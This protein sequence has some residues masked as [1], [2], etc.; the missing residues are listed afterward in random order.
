MMLSG[1]CR[2]KK[3]G[4]LISIFLAALLVI[5][6]CTSQA[7][8][9]SPSPTIPAENSETLPAITSPGLAG[10]EEALQEIYE[11]VNPSVVNI[12]VLQKEEAIFPSFPEIPGFP[13]FGFPIPEQPEY[14][15][16]G[17]G[18]GFVWDK[19]GH[20]VT[21][22]HVVADADRISVTF[23]DGTTVSGEV[24]GNDADSDLAVVKVGVSEEQ[25]QPVN[26]ADSTRLK[27]GQMAVAIGNPFGLKGTMTVGFVSALGRLLP[28]ESDTQTGSTYSIPDVIQTDAAVNPG[29]SG[30]VLVDH[31]GEVIGVTTAIISPVQASAGIGFAVPSAIVKKVVPA[32]IETGYFEHPWLGISG[33]SLSPEL[34]KAMDLDPSQRGALI[35]D[36]V[37]DSPADE[38]GLKGSDRQITIDGENVRVGGDV[39]IA[40]DGHAVKEFSDLVTYLA[41]NTEVGQKVTL[42]LLHRGDETDIEVALAARPRENIATT[43]AKQET[44]NAWLGIL[45]LTLSPEIADAMSLPSGQK[46]VLVEQVYGGSPAD[47]AGLRGSYKPVTIDG[48][49]LLIG[50]DV[51]VSLDDQPIES[52]EDLKRQI[53]RRQPEGEVTLIIVRD[54]ERI[55]LKVALGE[56]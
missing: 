21:N 43:P 9:E 2:M 10:F 31:N 22:N 54:G 30:G 39:V 34:A 52:V 51:I 29:N 13:F 49:R 6:G 20:I 5:P 33:T 14:Y 8:I 1:R 41:R 16:H 11:R 44:G 24:I 26:I 35:V 7:P 55:S 48:Q 4:W 23:H 19:E 25:L 53:E 32:L 38:A 56:K 12:K 46:G 17:L 42:T 36:V 27:V 28:A 45:G 37:P 18:S 50:G 40:I 47:E 3:Y 15:S